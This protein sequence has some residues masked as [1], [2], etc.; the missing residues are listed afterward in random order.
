VKV[1]SFAP[2]GTPLLVRRA[3]G[4]AVVVLAL[5]IR[6]GLFRRG[7]VVAMT[8]PPAIESFP[9]WYPADALR[10]PAP[11]RGESDR[12]LN[13]GALTRRLAPKRTSP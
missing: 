3:D 11:V 10:F 6:G 8:V 5:G 7:Q 2:L 9:R 4:Q 13:G 12:P 1:S